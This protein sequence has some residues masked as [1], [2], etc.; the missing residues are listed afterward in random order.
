MYQTVQELAGRCELHLV[1]LLDSAGQVP[2]MRTRQRLRIHSLYGSAAGSAGAGGLHRTS[3]G[4][5]F[6]IPD[7]AWLIHRQMFTQRIDVVQLEYTVLG[8]YAGQFRRIPS[9][10]FEHDVYFQ[11]IARRLPF[12]ASL[13]ERIQARWEYLRALRW[14]LRMLPN[15]D[16]IQVCSRDNADYLLSFLPQL[17]GQNRRWIPRWNRHV[18][19]Y[20]P[21]RAASRSQSCFWE[22]SATPNLEALTWF[23]DRCSRWYWPRSRARV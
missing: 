8:Q 21:H 15:L 11:S 17:K 16:R 3:R 12:I 7:L 5:Q 14:E 22:A 13:V 19:L 4:S 1:V 10:L 9:I 6:R 23:V 2:R 20:L 18:A